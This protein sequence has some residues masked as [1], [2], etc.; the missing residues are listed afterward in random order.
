MAPPAV[1]EEARQ[2]INLIDAEKT[3]DDGHVEQDRRPGHGRHCTP[4]AKLKGVAICGDL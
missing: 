2:M 1:E 3:R 4:D